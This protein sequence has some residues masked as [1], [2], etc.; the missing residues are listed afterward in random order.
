MDESWKN[1]EEATKWEAKWHGDCISAS[2]GEEFKQLAYAKRMG[3]KTFHDGR[4]PFVFN[5]QGRSVL[6]IGGGSCSLL[7][8]CLNR[9]VSVV[10]DPCD[11][12]EWVNQ[13]YIAA[14]ITLA[15]IKAEDLDLSSATLGAK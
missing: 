14:G 11:Y 3:L 13:R 15:K 6:D 7:L 2:F 8:K 10:V 1:W 12:P 5:L 4:S 9:G